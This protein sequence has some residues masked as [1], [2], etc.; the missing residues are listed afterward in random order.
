MN[1]I[2]VERGKFYYAIKCQNDQCQE[3][4]PVPPRLA[5]EETQKLRDQLQDLTVRCQI[6]TQETRVQERQIYLLEMR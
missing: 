2:P 4:L 6:C 3:G 5:F 1:P